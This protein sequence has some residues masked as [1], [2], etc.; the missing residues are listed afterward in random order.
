MPN[1]P[2]AGG[3]RFLFV[4]PPLTGHVN[5]T[6]PLGHE[7]TRRGHTVAWAGHV[8]NVASLLGP[9]D[10]FFPV[11]ER[12]LPEVEET[13]DS[14]R[15]G[16]AGLKTTWEVYV[17]G[18]ARQ[19][20]PGLHAIVDFRPDLL[21]VDQQTVAGAAVAEVHGLPWATSASTPFELTNQLDGT[22]LGDWVQGLLR[23]F[24]VAT[25]VDERRAAAV[26]PRLSPHLVVAYTTPEMAGLAGGAPEHYALVGPLIGER[27]ETI[28]FP[29]EWLD[30][31]DG[32]CVLVSLGTL[33]W[34]R[35]QRFFPVVAE[36]FAAMQARAIVVAPPHL[37]PEPP[38][39]VLVVER[40]PQLEL[41]PRMDAVVCHGGHNTVCE[42]LACG[43]PLVI[44]PIHDDQPM[45]ADRVADAG[46]GLRVK[47]YRLT[48]AMLRQAVESVLHEPSYREGAARLRASFAAAGG[49]PAAADRLEALLASTTTRP[50]EVQSL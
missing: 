10:T 4:V 18:V 17:L 37:L 45:I 16:P 42:A 47:F 49:A 6:I 1:R 3:G 36:A 24:M 41:L 43:L 40:V 35:G 13:L 2:G 31:G 20:V 32:P 38:P 29:W 8:D 9:S 26:D 22:K 50:A 48:P 15:R 44:A 30:R 25:G 12:V 23:D 33:N 27:A 5:P 11:A 19:M 21:V 14:S 28:P 34:R 46:A 7:L 39:N